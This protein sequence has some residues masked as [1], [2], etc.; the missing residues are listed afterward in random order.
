[1]TQTNNNVKPIESTDLFEIGARLALKWGSDATTGIVIAAKGENVLVRIHCGLM[2][3]TLAELAERRAVVM[4][5]R[6]SFWKRLFG[7]SNDQRHPVGRERHDNE[8]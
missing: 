1:M 5:P 4:P 7:I 3:F 2:L 6:R 8:A